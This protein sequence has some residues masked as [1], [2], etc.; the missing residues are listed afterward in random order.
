M[1]KVNASAYRLLIFPIHGRIN[2][3]AR[4]GT[5]GTVIY[6]GTEGEFIV[7]RSGRLYLGPENQEVNS[8]VYSTIFLSQTEGYSDLLPRISITTEKYRITC[9]RRKQLNSKLQVNEKCNSRS[10][11]G[12]WS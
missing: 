4:S 5:D 12:N 8:T 7:G 3:K 9:K 1:T 10:E 2:L 6:L 11:C